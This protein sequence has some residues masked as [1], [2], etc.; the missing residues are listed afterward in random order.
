MSNGEWREEAYEM[1]PELNNIISYTNTPYLLWMELNNEFTKAYKSPKNEELIER[2]YE[3]FTWCCSQPEAENAEDDLCTCAMVCF[4]EHIPE[5][6]AA[7][8]DMPWWFDREDIYE[9]KDI[10][11]H[12]VGK[13][14]F[15]K[16][17]KVFDKF[18]QENP[19][20]D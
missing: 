11:T 18:E 17:M 2:I 20:L 13:T 15:K 10:F 1:F 3:Y 4:L 16:I 9:F 12:K 5:V 19:D 7:V 6:P 8:E 14:G